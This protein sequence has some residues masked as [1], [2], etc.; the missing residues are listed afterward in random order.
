MNSIQEEHNRGEIS[1]NLSRSVVLLEGEK[2]DSFN[3]II[4]RHGPGL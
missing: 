1:H 4:T 2:S 3:I